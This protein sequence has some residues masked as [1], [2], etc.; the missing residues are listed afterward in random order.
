MEFVFNDGGRKLA[1][2]KG[3]TGD[4]VTRSV[5]I[6]T[7]IDYQ[8]IYDDFNR[9]GT[10]QFN[11]QRKD[12]KHRR[13][14]ARMGVNRKIYQPY[15][16]SR[17]WIWNP[18]MGIGTGCKVHLKESEL[19]RGRLIVRLSKH[20]TCVIDGVIQDTYN[21]DRFETRCVY[22]YFYKPNRKES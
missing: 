14:R 13:S 1:G 7:Q 3:S 19:P 12:S 20:I 10:E 17:D 18:T 21:P 16:E 8:V 4:C 22:G 11:K 6:A 15:L 2:Y 5:T 9:L